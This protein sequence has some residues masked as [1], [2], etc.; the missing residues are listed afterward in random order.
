MNPPQMQVALSVVADP[1]TLLLAAL[2]SE[3]LISHVVGGSGQWDPA[4]Y[5]GY[6]DKDDPAEQL[7]R[8][9]IHDMILSVQSNASEGVGSPN[10]EASKE[11]PS[12][13]D[14][15]TRL[16]EKTK[17]SSPPPLS[18][19]SVVLMSLHKDT[20]FESRVWNR[21]NGDLLVTRLLEFI[22]FAVH[23]EGVMKALV[24]D[25]DNKSNSIVAASILFQLICVRYTSSSYLASEVEHRTL[26]KKG[27]EEAKR[28]TQRAR[29]RGSKV[30][31]E[32]VYWKPVT[33]TVSHLEALQTILT[34]LGG[35]AEGHFHTSP[36]ASH[37]RGGNS[38]G[39]LGKRFSSIVDKVFHH[40]D[41]PDNSAASTSDFT[42]NRGCCQ[43]GLGRGY[44]ALYASLLRA[45]AFFV[46]VDPKA[47]IRHYSAHKSPIPMRVSCSTAMF[48]AYAAGCTTL[49]RY[50]APMSPSPLGARFSFI[51]PPPG[52]SSAREVLPFENSLEVAADLLVAS[53]ASCEVCGANPECVATWQVGAML[54]LT[55]FPLVDLPT[56]L[57]SPLQPRAEALQQLVYERLSNAIYQ[58]TE[59]QSPHLPTPLHFV[60]LGLLP[61]QPAAI[62]LLVRAANGFAATL[63]DTNEG[64]APPSDGEAVERDCHLSESLCKVMGMA[65]TPSLRRDV[66]SALAQHPYARSMG[67]PTFLRVLFS[68]LFLGRSN[69]TR[70]WGILDGSGAGALSTQSI[71][72]MS[73]ALCDGM[74]LGDMIG[75]SLD[76]PMGRGSGNKP[77]VDAHHL[78]PLSAANLQLLAALV[79]N[80]L[81]LGGVM[82]NAE[83]RA[84]LLD[85]LTS[86]SA[87]L[88]AAIS[89]DG[90]PGQQAVVDYIL[91]SRA[92]AWSS[93]VG[94]VLL[95]LAECMSPSDLVGLQ[96]V[97]AVSSVLIAIS[98]ETKPKPPASWILGLVSLVVSRLSSSVTAPFSASPFGE[99]VFSWAAKTYQAVLQ[100]PLSSSATKTQKLPRVLAVASRLIL[101]LQILSTAEAVRVA[102][103]L[104]IA[105]TYIPICE[106]SGP[107]VIAPAVA[108]AAFNALV[109]PIHEQ[110]PMSALCAATFS[111]LYIPRPSAEEQSAGKKSPL[112]LQVVMGPYMAMRLRGVMQSFEL[113]SVAK[114][115]DTIDRHPE[116][117]EYLAAFRSVQEV[118]S[119][120]SLTPTKCQLLMVTMMFENARLLASS[121][122]PY[123]AGLII[124]TQCEDPRVAA[125]ACGAFELMVAGAPPPMR[126]V[127]YDQIENLTAASRTDSTKLQLTQWLLT[128]QHQLKAPS[129][130]HLVSMRQPG[131][132]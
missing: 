91:G 39:I 49:I 86:W 99:A 13:N 100:S 128:L 125:R 8:N 122:G 21:V 104:R 9:P 92:Q 109:A 61:K 1:E 89:K 101:P 27:L 29:L 54:A 81:F 112:V 56:V 121:A 10:S 45:L 113:C 83:G 76:D 71:C 7:Q 93:H 106:G 58:R 118:A 11:S 62:S 52:P 40:K 66:P 43:R 12:I 37:D 117:R 2:Q 23:V 46:T 26:V 82:S 42:P 74:L 96:S 97:L 33:L 73:D 24:G 17:T 55:T 30:T 44:Q 68:M 103:P 20:L 32:A 35:F 51:Q 87:K 15:A 28:R 85:K 77:P 67:G 59:G 129:G 53:L 80:E 108:I 131:G 65:S 34:Y 84:Y 107:Y 63:R 5:S 18:T 102:S 123:I 69:V 64:D 4:D 72:A 132:K 130:V 95:R 6:L 78:A 120:G 116:V 94:A 111:G 124:L 38:D 115:G 19:K 57:A 79:N 90:R 25:K 88:W 16:D 127:L 110:H 119:I 60:L 36:H 41:N 47:T 98:S 70:N 114:L 48:G 126:K 22:N 75:S 3:G 31:S 14:V 50:L 105:N